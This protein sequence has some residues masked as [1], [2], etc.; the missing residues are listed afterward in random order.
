[1]T[2]TLERFTKNDFDQLIGW[3]DSA[4][5]CMQWGGPQ[6]TW[7]LTH[8]QLDIYLKEMEGDEPE[9]LIYRAVSE[10]GRTVGHIS[11]GRLDYSNRTGRMGK[12]L[13]GDPAMRGKGIAGNMVREICRIGFEELALER[14]SLGVF[15][16]NESAIAAYEK[17][18]FQ[19]EGFFRKFRQVGQRRWHLVEMSILK[20]EW[21][22]RQ[23]T[24][25]WEGLKR[26]TGAFLSA[27]LS[28]KLLVMDR[29]D[30]DT[31]IW[32]LAQ[33]PVI[34]WARPDD[35]KINAEEEGYVHLSWHE[36]EDGNDELIVQ[37]K[38]TPSPLPYIEA[39]GDMPL[40]AN[41]SEYMFS[42]RQIQSVEGYGYIDQGKGVLQSLICDLG[43]GFLFV[44]AA[45]ILN[46]V[47]VT[48]ER[49][50]PHPDDI[51]LF[52]WQMEE[53]FDD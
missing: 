25:Q 43:D 44:S 7:P 33:D 5:F 30:P 52:D 24:H 50:A 3:V 40:S 13:V 41:C 11:L 10:D 14:I 48:K 22:A 18:G 12:V 35:E 6:F 37:M 27:I 51:V 1:M 46:D 8:E 29:K 31:A 21:F 38:D 36:R 9:R 16:F 20:D 2:I 53:V 42:D 23:L 4:E 15:D 26:M 49:P 17:A 34:R 28:E 19:K 32:L 45:P 47:F 39:D